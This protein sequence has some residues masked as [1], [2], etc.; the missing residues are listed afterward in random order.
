MKLAYSALAAASL[1]AMTQPAAAQQAD[2]PAATQMAPVSDAELENFVI[3]ASMIQQVQESAEI[4]QAEKEQA[5]MQVLAQAQMT[6]E[7]FN[8][9]GAALQTSE[10][11]QARVQQTVTRL[12][13]EAQAQG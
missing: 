9:I 8:S 4:A 7:R 3:A 10:Q 13:A 1:A 12:R 2:A 5:S 6:P 11:L